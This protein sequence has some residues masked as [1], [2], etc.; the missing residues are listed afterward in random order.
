VFSVLYDEKMG[1]SHNLGLCN[2]TK[3]NSERRQEKKYVIFKYR[4][5]HLD[6]DVLIKPTFKKTHN[7]SMSAGELTPAPA[8]LTLCRFS[9]HTELSFAEPAAL[10]NRL[11]KAHLHMHLIL[12]S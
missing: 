11:K 12:G 5:P 6:M 1:L 8:V 9:S 2:K 4:V 10:F 7:I 3:R